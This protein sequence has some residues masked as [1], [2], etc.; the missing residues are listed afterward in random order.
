VLSLGGKRFITVQESPRQQQQQQQQPEE[1]WSAHGDPLDG[2]RCFTDSGMQ[3]ICQ[4]SKL[5][6]L[7]LGSLQDVTAAGLAGLHKLQK[8]KS[9]TLE[10]L[11]CAISLSAVP[12]FSQLTHLTALRLHWAQT[13]PPC[14]FDPSILAHLTQLKCLVL[15]SCTPARGTAGAAELLSR[16]SRL[17]QLRDL[18]LRWIEAL[19]QCPPQ[20]FSSLTSSS[21]L[22][23]LTLVTSE[24]Y[25]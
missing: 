9:L 13:V 20:A 22:E 18:D 19:Q 3:F 16:L 15:V 24:S 21:M 1:L 23:S 2:H 5:Q 17:P 12:A 6:M 14:T 7:W 11:T 10:D 4:R 25:W 8:L